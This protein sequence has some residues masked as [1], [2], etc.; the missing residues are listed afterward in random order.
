MMG[1]PWENP[2]LKEMYA[3]LRREQYGELDPD[4]PPF[5]EDQFQRDYYRARRMK[6]GGYGSSGQF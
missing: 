2:E 4:Y 6:G 1:A 5:D 3:A